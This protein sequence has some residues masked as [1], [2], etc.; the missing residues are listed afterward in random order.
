M[1]F[2]TVSKAFYSPAEYKKA[3]LCHYMFP[4]QN[5]KIEQNSKVWLGLEK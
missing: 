2:Q 4:Y 1:L 3:F 5:F